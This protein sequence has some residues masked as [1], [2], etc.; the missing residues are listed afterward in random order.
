MPDCLIETAD[1]APCL[2]LHS[3]PKAALEAWL[4]T[5]PE[6]VKVWLAS[7]GFEAKLGRSSLLPGPDG[8][9]AGALVIPNNPP[10]LWDYAGLQ[11]SL[12]PGDWALAGDLTDDIRHKAALGWA[13]AGYRFDR[14]KKSERE[15]R[16]L[17]AGDAAVTGEAAAL[18]D[19]IHLGR[20]LVNTPANDMGPDELEAA[21]RSVAEAYDAEI[22]TIEG[23]ALLEKNFPAVH[24]VGRASSR[25][26]RVIDLTWGDADAPKLTLVGKGVCFDTGGLD[27]KPAS[28][29]A[30]MKKDMGG[31]ATTL[32]TAK[33]VM[34][35]NLPVRLRLLIGAV[36]NSV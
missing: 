11:K 19:A 4:N 17:L 1:D 9:L 25:A 18:A 20:D 29:M 36:E 32:A 26:P 27:L 33:A 22:R 8:A 16:R 2:P 34:A 30:I 15:P 35:L 6:T 21:C 28:A 23:D 24:T 14:Y 10:S 3:V 7:I 13:L 5:Q 12:P 31:A